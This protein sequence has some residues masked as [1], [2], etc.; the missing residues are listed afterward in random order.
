[1][2]T[3]AIVG[4]GRMGSSMARA[5][6]RSGASLVLYNRTPER[7]ATL[8]TELRGGTRVVASPREAAATADVTITML[9]NDEAVRSAFLGPDGL[10]AGAHPGSVLVDMSTV[11]PDTIRSV[12]TAVRARG[13]GILDAPVSGSIALATAGT[14]TLMVGGTV[15]DLDRAR[16]VLEAVSSTIFHL[17]PL[18]SGSAMKLAVN[19]LIFGLNGALAEGLVLAEAAGVDRALAYEV[20]AASAAGAPYV[21]YKQAAFVEPDSTPVGFSL[22]LAEKDLRLITDFAAALG[23][24]M[25]QARTN[26]AL[27]REASIEGRADNDFS[28]VASELRARRR[29]P[30]GVGPRGE[31]GPD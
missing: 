17:G 22:E 30:A 27:V 29:I 14:L 28:T 25:P 11:M 2:T 4:T 20:F 7:A 12:E 19:T 3:V 1:M 9:A 31:E 10:A 13:A 21:G 6:A 24:D 18:G 26:L 15:E 5:L 8:A 23:V 16:P